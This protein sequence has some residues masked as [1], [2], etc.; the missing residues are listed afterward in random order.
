MRVGEVLADDGP[1]PTGTDGQHVPQAGPL[2]EVFATRIGEGALRGLHAFG[3]SPEP[4]P[5]VHG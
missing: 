5:I 2:A 3:S 1:V 4:V